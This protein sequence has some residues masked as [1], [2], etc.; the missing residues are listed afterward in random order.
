M[1]LKH[2]PARCCC[3]NIYADVKQELNKVTIFLRLE[4]AR[5]AVSSPRLPVPASS[6]GPPPRRSLDIICSFG[7]QIT[8]AIDLR[9]LFEKLS[10]LL[11]K[12]KP[13]VSP[14]E[15]NQLK[16]GP[17]TFGGRQCSSAVNSGRT[18]PPHGLLISRHP[19]PLNKFPHYCIQSFSSEF[20]LWFN[21]IGL[22]FVAC[23]C[24]R[25]LCYF[26]F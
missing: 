18:A 24:I 12:P 16:T 11:G 1:R 8:T 13:N 2:F 17:L 5:L 25:E 14:Q 6:A 9:D 22:I 7:F 19:N 3:C 20:S 26:V 10:R 21:L 23:H 4:V 15:T